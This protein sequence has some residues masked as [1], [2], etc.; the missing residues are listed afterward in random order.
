MCVSQKGQEA[1]L[2]HRARMP[3]GSLY[4]LTKHR[5]QLIAHCFI[6][7]QAHYFLLELQ[8]VS[9]DLGLCVQ[10]NYFIILL[11]C[12]ALVQSIKRRELLVILIFYRKS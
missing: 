3:T 12:R 11:V 4:E 2:N 9:L 1:L 7:L 5:L 8:C 10:S 6:L